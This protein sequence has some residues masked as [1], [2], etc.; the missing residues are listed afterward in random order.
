MHFPSNNNAISISNFR[1]FVDASQGISNWTITLLDCF[2]AVLKANTLG[3]FNFRDF[4]PNE[5]DKYDKLQNGD[6]N[7][8]LPRK[9]LAFIGPTDQPLQSYH[10][11]SFYTQYF[12]ENDVRTVIR[13]NSATYNPAVY[14]GFIYRNY[15]M[16]SAIFLGFTR[17]G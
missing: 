11:P 17:P 10:S 2:N 14:F 16:L 6:L 3:F 12:L 13:L 5:Y 8:L 9:F 4:N 15:Q 7:W 1:P